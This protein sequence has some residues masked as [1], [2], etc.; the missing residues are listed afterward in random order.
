VKR[1]RGFWVWDRVWETDDSAVLTAYVPPM[2]LHTWVCMYAVGVGDG[3][4]IWRVYRSNCSWSSAMHSHTI[5]HH[6][7]LH[8]PWFEFREA[9]IPN[10]SQSI[11]PSL[12][13]ILILGFYIPLFPFTDG[14]YHSGT[15]SSVRG[16]IKNPHPVPLEC[17]FTYSHTDSFGF[18]PCVAP[19]CAIGER[20]VGYDRCSA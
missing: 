13:S 6:D 4:L 19:V 7:R 20:I 10:P 9:C 5:F 8:F 11:F 16:S 12:L 17:L 14:S 18:A 3:S 1:K 2:Y 15:Y